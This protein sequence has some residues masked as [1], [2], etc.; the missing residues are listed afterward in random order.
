VI[1]AHRPRAEVD[2]MYGLVLL[3]LV[4]AAEQ[5]HARDADT[6]TQ[7]AKVHPEPRRRRSQ[8]VLWRAWV[9]LWGDAAP[10]LSLAN[11]APGAGQR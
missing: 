11:R 4:N 1:D 2:I 5:D 7:Q 9:A 6:A 10:A 8:H 3:D